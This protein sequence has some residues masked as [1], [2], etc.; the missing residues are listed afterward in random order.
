MVIVIPSTLPHP[1]K[2]AIVP[3]PTP[4]DENLSENHRQN[5]NKHKVNGSERN[6]GG[7]PPATASPGSA[8]PHEAHGDHAR[9]KKRAL[10]GPCITKEECVALVVGLARTTAHRTLSRRI[11]R[12]HATG[13]ATFPDDKI[14]PA[15]RIDTGNG[16]MKVVLTFPST[17]TFRT[18]SHRVLLCSGCHRTSVYIKKFVRAAGAC[19]SGRFRDVWVERA[20]CA[21][22]RQ[23][24]LILRRI[25]RL[26]RCGSCD[27]RLPI[28]E[29]AR[30]ARLER[31]LRGAAC[32]AR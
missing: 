32:G 1:R 4:V 3:N 5:P 25:R 26:S 20:G 2:A 22:G 7:V 12:A 28:D 27:P 24:F 21:I 31:M 6:S 10:L 8:H 11:H 17:V 29:T 13:R 18:F 16:R 9:T 15:H 23:L 19:L 14:C 30:G